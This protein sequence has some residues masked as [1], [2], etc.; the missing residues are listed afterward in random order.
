MSI[1]VSDVVEVLA[2]A[3]VEVCV[4]KHGPNGFDM[5]VQVAT[6]QHELV[7][8]LLHRKTEPLVSKVLATF[9]L[10]VNSCMT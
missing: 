2:V 1:D 5:Y 4:R 10:L 6:S 7:H 3:F 8:R 9:M